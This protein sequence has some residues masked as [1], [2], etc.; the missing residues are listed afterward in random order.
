MSALPLNSMSRALERLPTLWSTVLVRG[1]PRSA[2]T[3]ISPRWTSASHQIGITFNTWGGVTRRPWQRMDVADSRWL[4]NIKTHIFVCLHCGLCSDLFE[5]YVF[6]FSRTQCL[7][8]SFCRTIRD[9]STTSSSKTWITTKP[10]E[11]IWWTR[12]GKIQEMAAQNDPMSVWA[13]Q[14]NPQQYKGTSGWHTGWTCHC[15]KTFQWL[16][17]PQEET[18]VT[19][20]LLTNAFTLLKLQPVF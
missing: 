10:G 18:R 17:L 7:C 4:T 1:E 16:Q 9:P 13:N 19:R 3:A 20:V 6:C 15:F 2:A 14:S 11:L 8:A 12:P 5:W